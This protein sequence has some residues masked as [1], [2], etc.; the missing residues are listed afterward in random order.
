VSEIPEIQRSEINLLNEF[1]L[2]EG[3]CI[4]DISHEGCSKM[5]ESER[6]EDPNQ[7][8]SN[9]EYISDICTLYFDGSK[10]FEGVGVGCMTI[11]PKDKHNF[12]SCK[13]EFE[14]TNNTSEYETLV[15]G[16]K[17]S[18]DMKVENIK[19]FG[20]SKIVVRQ[21]KNIIHCNYLHLRN[22]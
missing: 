4:N 18:I 11:N 3:E 20:D 14:C 2:E 6:E 10:S 16:L 1:S 13:L 7:N 8:T 15:Q 19:D 12:L 21:I 22:Y 9:L 5:R 17:K